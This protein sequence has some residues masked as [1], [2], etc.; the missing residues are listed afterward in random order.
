MLFSSAQCWSR[1]ARPTTIAETVEARWRERAVI[2]SLQSPRIII[3]T[4]VV[5]SQTDTYRQ[6]LLQK[7]GASRHIPVP[8]LVSV[9]ASVGRHHH[10]PDLYMVRTCGGAESATDSQHTCTHPA[11]SA[12]KLLEATSPFDYRNIWI[13][14]PIDTPLYVLA[15]CR[16]MWRIVSQS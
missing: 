6:S 7:Y 12:H 15:L 4:K 8:S 10:I 13:H 1:P 16:I 2:Y 5:T 11:R 9:N 14:V 3:R